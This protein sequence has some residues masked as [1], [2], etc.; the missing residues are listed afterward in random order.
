MLSIVAIAHSHGTWSA[1]VCGLTG[2]GYQ[3]FSPHFHMTLQM[4]HYSLALG[5]IPIQVPQYQA[6]DAAQFLAA[7]ERNSMLILSE[8]PDSPEEDTPRRHPRHHKALRIIGHI[9]GYYWVG[10]SA[11][12]DHLSLTGPRPFS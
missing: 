12:W 7:V 8:V 4:P 11:P 10:V 5:G 1:A 6:E 3:V 2:A 9:L